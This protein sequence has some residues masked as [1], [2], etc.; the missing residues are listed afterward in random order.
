MEKLIE[1]QNRITTLNFRILVKVE[2]FP[3][4]S[5]LE[6]YTSK[7]LIIIAFY[8]NG[9][10]GVSEITPSN[11]DDRIFTYYD[12]IEFEDFELA[13]DYTKKLIESYDLPPITGN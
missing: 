5:E 1:F 12:D 2:S 9:I 3:E 8:N 10:Y 13:F 7:S 6:I 11:I 4:S